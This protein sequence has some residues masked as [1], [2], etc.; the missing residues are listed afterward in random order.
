MNK[1]L[2]NDDGSTVLDFIRGISSQLVVLG[3][4]LSFYGIMEFYKIPVIQNFGVMVF[5]ILSGFLITQTTILKGKAYGC[6]N[7]LIDRFS[8]IYSA[9]LPA[10]I[11]V[12][13]TDFFL[14]RYGQYPGYDYSLRSFLG[15]IFMLQ[16]HPVFRH[17]GIQPFGSARP[18]WTVSVEWFF[19]I[20]FGVIYY[21]S[22]KKI[23][24]GYINFI[25]FGLSFIMVFY[26]FGGGQQGLS[27]YWLL[28]SV[29]SYF[30]NENKL[31][32]KSKATYFGLL[33]ILIFGMIFRIYN[34]KLIEM[35]DIGLAINFTLIFL[36]L[37][38]PSSHL[39]FILKKRYF[40][41]FS[42]WL[43]SYSYSL[44]LIHYTY[45]VVFK[46]SIRFKSIYVNILLIFVLVNIVSY[47]F[48]L[49]F[50]KG[51]LTLRRKLK[52]HLSK[53]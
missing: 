19:Y 50:E 51:H 33:S 4:L 7:Y 37:L 11:L 18:F 5:F 1:R 47:L 38:N 44:Y 26:C 28:G 30:Y 40:R 42:S 15:N 45:I 20:F 12:L 27:Y 13:V 32:I 21:L 17:L 34:L 8:R 24:T 2:I 14:K 3:H 10:L 39:N 35:Y 9:F 43:A 6:K 22:I 23:L 46:Q 41:I 16:Y 29:S 25:L 31:Q 48:Y 36:L 52:F 53:F 49:F